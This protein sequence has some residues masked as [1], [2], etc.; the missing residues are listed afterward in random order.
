MASPLRSPGSTLVQLLLHLLKFGVLLG[1]VL[2]LSR[3]AEVQ[4]PSIS[5]VRSASSDVRSASNGTLSAVFASPEWLE[6]RRERLYKWMLKEHPGSAL[7]A[8]GLILFGLAHLGTWNFYYYF[9]LSPADVGLGYERLLARAGTLL[10]GVLIFWFAVL[11]LSYLLATLLRFV[12]RGVLGALVLAVLV[13]MVAR[14]GLGAAGAWEASR[15][16][17][18]VIFVYA[19]ILVLP[20]PRAKYWK[21]TASSLAVM[22]LAI[23]LGLLGRE[24][25][26]TAP[27]QAVNVRL[28]RPVDGT[29][30]LLDIPVVHVCVHHFVGSARADWS[31]VLLGETT[32]S[33]VIWRPATRSVVRL[34]PEQVMIDSYGVG[35]PRTNTC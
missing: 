35:N 24:V 32:N 20:S 16:V 26:V 31:G 9:G 11:A 28:D 17:A 21:L 6:S 34:S 27:Q 8:A 33:Y 15:E 13:A 22:L 30:E 25:F 18:S 12:G 4:V 3:S 29:L 1:V 19:V 7:A 23:G 14:L 10:A 2:R 5:N